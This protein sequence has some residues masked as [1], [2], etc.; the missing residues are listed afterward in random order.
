MNSTS[1]DLV[2]W[3]D[4]SLFMYL[5]FGGA[6]FGFVST[7][8]FHL[9]VKSADFKTQE[10]VKNINSSYTSGFVWFK[11]LSFYSLLAFFSLTWAELELIMTYL[12]FYLQL[13]LELKI[14]NLF[15]LF[16]W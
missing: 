15:Q 3:E 11:R 14:R 10:S 4:R 5:G 9:L 2:G 8:I 12:P 13:T 1:S 6:G 16:H 7:M